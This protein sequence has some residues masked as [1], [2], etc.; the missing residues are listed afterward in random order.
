MSAETS[1]T[2]SIGAVWPPVVSSNNRIKGFYDTTVTSQQEVDEFALAFSDYQSEVSHSPH[3]DRLSIRVVASLGAISTLEDRG[4]S[5][6]A[7]MPIRGSGD[8]A[9]VY[10]GWNGPER[11][12]SDDALRL[13]HLLLGDVVRM[14]Q[15]DS[16][17]AERLHEQGFTPRVIDHAT[18]DRDKR[19]M[20]ERFANL[21]SA[22]G[23]SVA[24]VEELLLNPANT[25]AYVENE[26]GVVSTGMAERATVSVDGFG[27]LH[28][29]EITEAFTL[30]AYRKLGLYQAI[31]G[32]LLAR[33]LDPAS[34]RLEV[35]YGESNLAMPGVVI[36]A[37]K[38]GRRMSYL[39]R[40]DLRVREPNFGILQQSFHIED[41]EEM[42]RYNDF[43]VSY[44][45][46]WTVDHA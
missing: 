18:P 1:E 38:N 3:L 36:A 12:A 27:D 29:A 46:F 44:V 39:D 23:Y 9:V 8:L 20:V 34:P 2:S 26:E 30:P 28:M 25:I 24:E 32:N 11:R 13:H 16:D 21:Y 41:G 5:L 15:H 43:A 7:A 19:S 42:R 14:P 37:H 45:P 35:I 40:E 22:F 4:V 31:S 33:L 10:T 6:E 17:G